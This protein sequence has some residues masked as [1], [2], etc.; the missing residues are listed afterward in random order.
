MEVS[1]HE[2]LPR[3]SDASNTEITTYM[4]PGFLGEFDYSTLAF[5]VWELVGP[6]TWNPRPDILFPPYA[7]IGTH[8]TTIY[9]WRDSQ[10][11][12]VQEGSL[13]RRLRLLAP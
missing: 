8:S 9:R 2:G 3:P 10:A 4:W 6:T 12:W 5:Q 1:Y 7:C 11:E 13:V